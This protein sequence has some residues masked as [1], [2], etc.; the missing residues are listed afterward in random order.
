MA[1]DVEREDRVLLCSQL[2]ESGS[3]ASEACRFFSA[4]ME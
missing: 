2:P 1:N 3:W 4:A